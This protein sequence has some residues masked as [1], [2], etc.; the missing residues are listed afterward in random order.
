MKKPPLKFIER[1]AYELP[2]L[3]KDFNAQTARH[4]E[5]TEEQRD[6]ADAIETHAIN[7]T[8]TILDGIEAIGAA[9][10]SA[11]SNADWPLG[12]R[13]VGALGTL[14]THLAVELQYL[15]DV[16]SDM[17]TRIEMHDREAIAAKAQKGGAK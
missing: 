4:D 6:K 1:P 10:F 16:Q 5:M 15:S 13:T 17:H 7:A 14:I 11:G 3:L 8:Q 2:N 9:M 12:G